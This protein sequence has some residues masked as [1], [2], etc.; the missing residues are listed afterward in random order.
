MA[1]LDTGA[2]DEDVDFVAVGED[3]GDEGG[4]GGGRGEV[5]GADGGF[6]VEG[7]DLLFCCLVCV[8]SLEDS[9]VS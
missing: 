8:V 3:A 6:A 5:C 9:Y 1:A 7:L 2:V 4:D